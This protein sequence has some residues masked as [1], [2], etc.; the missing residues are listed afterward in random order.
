MGILNLTPD[1]FSDGGQFTTPEEA[2]LFA[3]KLLDEGAEVIDVGGD[4]SGPGSRCV[5]VE[6]EWRRIEAVLQELP[7]DT[8]VS[9]DTHHAEVA[10]RS[11]EQGVSI[12]NDVSGWSSSKML[13]IVGATE[14]ARLVMMYSSSGVPHVFGS[15]TPETVCRSI[16]T[17]F[18]QSIERAAEYGIPTDRLILDPGMGAF[19]SSDPDVSWAVIEYFG[20]FVQFGCP[21]LLG[22]SRKGFLK[23]VGSSPAERDEASAQ[24]AK[25][26]AEAVAGRVPLYVRAHSILI[27]Q[28]VLRSWE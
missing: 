4:A 23:R 1:S 11:L 5:G 16:E 7:T 13:E 22:V 14:A 3:H 2:L 27:H 19:L 12:I 24:I 26:V 8:I 9:V 17:F 25:Q 6:E 28:T 15:A 21:L 10:E 20:E 18:E